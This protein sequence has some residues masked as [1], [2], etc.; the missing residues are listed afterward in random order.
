MALEMLGEGTRFSGQRQKTITHS[1]S[2]SQSISFSSANFLNPHPH[3]QHTEGQVNTCICTKLSNMKFIMCYRNFH[4]GHYAYL[5]LTLKG[6]TISFFK[7]YSLHRHAWN[8]VWNKGS[9][10]IYLKDVKT[11]KRIMENC[12][13]AISCPGSHN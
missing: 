4:N 12:P 1:S 7:V 2:S 3:K 6:D 13:P 10:C 5:P 9:Q 8:K 11:H